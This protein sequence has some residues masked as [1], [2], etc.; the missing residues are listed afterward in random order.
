M[1]NIIQMKKFIKEN[2]VLV[3]GI[4]LPLALVAL[5]A[6]A[7]I[8]PQYF[9]DDPKYDFIFSDGQYSQVEFRVVDRKVN[10]RLEPLRYSSDISIP[11]LYRYRATTKAVEEIIFKHPDLSSF[12]SEEP[13]NGKGV[14]TNVVIDPTKLPSAEQVQDASK[15]AKEI[16][17][18]THSAPYMAPVEEL[19]NMNVDS[20]IIAPD[21]YEWTNGRYRSGGGLFLL[22][23]GYSEDKAV[24]RKNGN[25]IPINYHPSSGGYYPSPK[26]IGW[27]IP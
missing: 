18:N 26:F 2:I 17:K 24:L 8:V 5:F 14:N 1:G 3:L 10:L 4:S 19:L 11:K 20:S 25:N 13:Y 7:G 16:S 23:G 21:G 12:V 27:V 9:V 15:I 6:L 22:G